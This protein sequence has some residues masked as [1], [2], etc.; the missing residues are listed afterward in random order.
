M[1]QALRR[2]L[3]LSLLLFVQPPSAAAQA[4]TVG[5]TSIGPTFDVGDSNYISGSLVTTPALA[6]AVSTLSVYVGPVDTLVANRQF[7]MAVYT[8][9][10][11]R[12]GAM[13]AATAVGVLV[14][15]AW[16]TLP[17]VLPLQASTAYWLVFNANGR[18]TA[19]DNMAIANTP[20]S[21]Q[22]FFTTA[23]TAFGQWPNAPPVTLTQ[24]LY[25]I[26]ATLAAAPSTAIPVTSTSQLQWDMQAASLAEAQGFSYAATV[27]VGT[28]Q[29]LTAGCVTG[30][31]L[32]V[33]SAPV[34]GM[35]GGQ[36]SITITAASGGSTSPI[37]NTV[38]VLMQV[39]AAPTTTTIAVTRTLTTATLVAT[40]TS[41]LGGTPDGF[42]VFK[43]AGQPLATV[44]LA[45]GVAS[46]TT[47]SFVF[48]PHL[49]TAEY[50]GTPTFALSASAGLLFTVDIVAPANLRVTP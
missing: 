33:C 36:H 8:D 44:A 1:G 49:V 7:Q 20:T 50:Q 5:V 21:T 12:P 11:G 39:T 37:S 3:L 23:S 47:T 30:V 41:P 43:D 35:T 18:S 15:N 17:L 28:P 34:P 16:N 42:I 9:A 46:W 24:G 38:V 4:V 29:P 26:Y 27:D 10:G 2:L 40:V 32:F 25:S 19:V 45:G 31:P 6:G 48:G 14:A 13:L 22:A